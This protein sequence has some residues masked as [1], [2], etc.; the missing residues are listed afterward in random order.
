VAIVL[1]VNKL[2]AMAKDTNGLCPITVGVVFFNLL[3]IPLCYSFGGH[4]KNTYPPH[5]F[6][7]STHGS[8]ETIHFGI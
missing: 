3:V 1:G 5:Q 2:L 6:Q 7:V 4:F 8:Y